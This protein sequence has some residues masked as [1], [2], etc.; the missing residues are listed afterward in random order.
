MKTT[1]ILL[2]HI[3]QH[4]GC[5]SSDI[6]KAMAKIDD[7]KNISSM[8]SALT[9]RGLLS[10]EEIFG[11]DNRKMFKYWIAGAEPENTEPVKECCCKRNET[12][13]RKSKRTGRAL[14]CNSM[15]Y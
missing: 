12:G 9:K 15:F 14:S 2:A 5:V 10:R 13:K 11:K 8:L 3:R 4:Q 7:S 6:Y 1:D